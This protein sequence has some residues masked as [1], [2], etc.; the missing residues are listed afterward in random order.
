MTDHDAFAAYDVKAQSSLYNALY[1]HPAVLG[2]LDD[3]SGLRILDAACGTGLYAR[4]LLD[5]GASVTGFDLSQ[6]MLDIAHHRLG[7][8]VELRR[9]DLNNPL[10]WAEEGSYDLALMALAIHYLPN[11]VPALGEPVC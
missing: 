1:D 6:K 9:H 7:H 11:P 8:E 2:L 5:R 3:I 4:E 10:D